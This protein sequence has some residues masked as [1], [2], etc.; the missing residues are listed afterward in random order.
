M[1][2]DLYK[3]A[4]VREMQSLPNLEIALGSVEDLDVCEQGRVRGVMVGAVTDSEGSTEPWY[5]RTQR[6]VITTGTFLRGV[7]HCGTERV[8]AGRAGDEAATVLADT[9]RRI[10]FK[11][12]RLKTGQNRCLYASRHAIYIKHLM[13]QCISNMSS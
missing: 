11:T 7:I 2:R 10:G 13:L 12:G 6:V 9:L 8:A 1:D 3:D 4:M 5:A